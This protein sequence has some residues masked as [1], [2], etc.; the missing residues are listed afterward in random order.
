M[1]NFK[2][3]FFDLGG[4]LFNLNTRAAFRAF[5]NLGMPIPEELITDNSPLNALPEGQALIKLIHR[6]DLGEVRAREFIETVRQQCR[7]GTT[8]EEILQAY[9]GMIDVPVGRLA[10]L[11]RLRTKY[12]VYLLSNI[13]DLHWEAAQRMAR[14]LGFPMEDCFDHCFC[15]FEMGV[16]KPDPAIFERAIRES[17]VNPAETLYIDDYAANVEAGLAAGLLAYKIE[18][19]TLELH[20]PRLFPEF[21]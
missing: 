2:N 7:P 20:I 21:A 12:R 10:L 13:G 15:S 14:E 18:G 4:V 8:E 1:E 5:K 19:N 11:K 17:G 9:N 16:A 6:M 3:I